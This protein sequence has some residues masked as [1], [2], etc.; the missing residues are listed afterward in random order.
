[1]MTL[2]AGARRGRKESSGAL[3]QEEKEENQKMERIAIAA[4]QDHVR[5]CIIQSVGVYT[6]LNSHTH[7]HCLTSLS[8]L[9]CQAM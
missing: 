4:G 7:T 9:A 1:M 2:S 8:H 5:G 3:N 6:V